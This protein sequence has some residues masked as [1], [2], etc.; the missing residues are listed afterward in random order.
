MAGGPMSDIEKNIMDLYSEAA[1]QFGALFTLS[2][3]PLSQSSIFQMLTEVREH[4]FCPFTNYKVG[5]VLE[6]QLSDNLYFYTYGLNVEDNSHN[7][8]SLH[9]EQNALARMISLLGG[10]AKFSSLWVMAAPADAV[11]DPT[12]QPSKSCGHCRQIMISLAQSMEEIYAVT[13]DGRFSSP[14]DNFEEGEFLP[15]AFSE[16]NVNPDSL[17]LNSNAALVHIHSK[18][19]LWKTFAEPRNLT[20]DQLQKCLKKL[21]PHIIDA[22]YQTSPITAC[23]VKSNN[24]Y[25]TPGVL[26]QDIAFLTTDTIFAAIGGAVTRFGAENLVFDEI[27]LA[28][29]ELNPEQLTSAEIEALTLGHYAH[30][31]TKVHF[32]TADQHACYTFEQCRRARSEMLNRIA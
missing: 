13:L 23:I 1:K 2:D 7:R 31:Q 17:K 24:G 22:D 11:P 3:Q 28:S 21:S 10:D 29:S 20:E 30:D 25:Y 32:Y 9:S 8:L 15:D 12:Q 19:E 16:K 4:S 26:V 6:V 18:L 27:H 14:P 5:A